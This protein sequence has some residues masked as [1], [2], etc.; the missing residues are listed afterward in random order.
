MTKLDSLW[1]GCLAASKRL[2]GSGVVCGKLRIILLLVLI[3]IYCCFATLS[4]YWTSVPRQIGMIF[5]DYLAE[6][7]SEHE[8]PSWRVFRQVAPEAIYRFFDNQWPSANRCSS[9]SGPSYLLPS[10]RWISAEE[11]RRCSYPIVNLGPEG[12]PYICN[13][14]HSD[15]KYIRCIAVFALRELTGI[16]QAYDIIVDHCPEDKVTQC[17]DAWMLWHRMN[18]N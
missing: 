8:E 9:S 16:D 2:K 4:S 18:K 13:W 12:I 15:S 5:A 17:V 11:L 7:M 1:T 6:K 14:V 3:S 10:G